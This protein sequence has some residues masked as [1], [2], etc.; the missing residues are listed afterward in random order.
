[1]KKHFVN[2]CF[3]REKKLRNTDLITTTIC[4]R[5]WYFLCLVCNRNRTIPKFIIFQR[6]KKFLVKIWKFAKA[7]ITFTFQHHYAL[8]YI[9]CPVAKYQLAENTAPVYLRKITFR[10]TVFDFIMSIHQSILSW[11][12]RYVFKSVFNFLRIINKQINKP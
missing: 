1:M 10:L 11:N 6:I 8:L 3:P 12:R 2:F 9:I 5:S 4:A 7:T